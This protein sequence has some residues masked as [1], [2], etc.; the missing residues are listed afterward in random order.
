[1]F[2]FGSFCSNNVSQGFSRVDIFIFTVLK[3]FLRLSAPDKLDKKQCE[4]DPIILPTNY[5][6]LALLDQLESCINFDIKSLHAMPKEM[7]SKVNNI[8]L[9]SS[10]VVVLYMSYIQLISEFSCVLHPAI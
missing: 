3:Y 5:N 6:P 10:F 2:S 1:M 4:S 7:E 9:F 8:V